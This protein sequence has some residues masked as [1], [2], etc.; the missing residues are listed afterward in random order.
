MSSPPAT[1]IS[2][3]EAQVMEVLWRSKPAQSWS[4]EDIAHALRD[5]QSW[6]LTTVKTLLNRLLNKGAISAQQDGRRY[7]Y[8]AVLQREPW[9][10]AQS[11]GLVDRLFDGRLSALVAHFSAHRKLKAADIRAL[12]KLIEDLEK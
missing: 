4:T 10:R 7:L 11:L 12:K 8:C 9:L 1:Q 6:Q 3:A 5:S 2:D